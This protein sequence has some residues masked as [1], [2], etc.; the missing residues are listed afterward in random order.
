[1]NARQLPGPAHGHRVV[2]RHER[3]HD[4]ILL[5]V[6]HVPRRVSLLHQIGPVLQRFDRLGRIELVDRA[7]RLPQPGK[8]LERA[9]LGGMGTKA[10]AEHA[11]C[12]IGQL[13]GRGAHFGPGPRRFIRIQSLRA[14][15]VGVV[16]E[17]EGVHLARDAIA[18]ALPHAGRLRPLEVDRQVDHLRV[19]D[20]IGNVDQLVLRCEARDDRVIERDEVGWS[21][22]GDRLDHLGG[23]LGIGHQ[24][25]FD[26][27]FLLRFVERLDPVID[28][29]GFGI[30]GMPKRDDLLRHRLAGHQAQRSDH[31]HQ[32]FAQRHL[33]LLLLPFDLD[34]RQN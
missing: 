11:G 22:G 1:M 26:A 6:D 18:L 29:V 19:L 3:I 15:Q 23:E 9:L 27:I 4:V 30:V 13:L 16:V 17:G 33:F 14:E 8:E 2:A 21:A 32:Q 20:P 28:H 10:N 7:A 24:P 5:L 34:S 12:R 25:R 31:Y